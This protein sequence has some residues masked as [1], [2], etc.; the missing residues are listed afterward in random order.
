LIGTVSNTNLFINNNGILSPKYIDSGTQVF[1]LS[2]IM[3]GG[4]IGTVKV[5]RAYGMHL[6][7]DLTKN[8]VFEIDMNTFPTNIQSRF[9]MCINPRSY[10][11]TY[12]TGFAAPISLT[13]NVWSI[14]YWLR[15]CYWSSFKGK[16]EVAP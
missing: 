8:T 7:I 2:T 9:T 11:A 16:V 15:G 12:S 14:S 1:D 4:T 3:T 5:T 13:A 10:T 6:G